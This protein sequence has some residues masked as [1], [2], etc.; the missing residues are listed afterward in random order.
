[1]IDLTLPALSIRQPWAWCIIRPD[2]T[3]PEERAELRRLGLI[4][5]VENRSWRSSHRGPLLVHAALTFDTDGYHWLQTAMPELRLP[6]PRDF[7]LGGVVGTASVA[8][9]VRTSDSPWFFGPWGLVLE[10]QTPA[11]FVAGRGMPGFFRFKPA[12]GGR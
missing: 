8:D 7:D 5:D 4:K 10:G 12:E 11:P 1:M 2:V 6:A 9:C 3:D